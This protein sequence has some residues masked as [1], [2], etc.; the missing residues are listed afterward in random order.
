MRGFALLR[1][2]QLT[3]DMRW[4]ADANR[5]VAR[6]PSVRLPA[7]DT[8]LLMAELKAPERAILPP[9][10]LPFSNSRPRRSA[11]RRL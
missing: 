11:V 4:V 9:F 6:A 10:L 5:V 3:G 7:L 8:A 1:L 2:H